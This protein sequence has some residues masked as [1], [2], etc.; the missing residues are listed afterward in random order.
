MIFF[1]VF[2][3][4]INF[5]NFTVNPCVVVK[6]RGNVECLRVEGFSHLKEKSTPTHFKSNL[7]FYCILGVN[8]I[9]VVIIPI[10]NNKLFAE[11]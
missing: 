8:C 6:T 10:G 5:H 1:L 7:V 11:N 2:G 9:V 3:F 4:I